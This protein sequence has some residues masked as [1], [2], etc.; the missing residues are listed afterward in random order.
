MSIL[1]RKQTRVAILASSLFLVFLVECWGIAIPSLWADEIATI[2]AA[3]RPLSALWVLLQKIDMVHG[4]YYLF[5]HFWGQAFGLSPFWLRLPS[6]VGITATC[7]V[8]WLIAK[9]IS[10]ERLAWM[11][12]AISALMP[13]MSWAATEGRSY[14]FSSLVG[15]LI[16]LF[17]IDAF[18]LNETRRP[19]R[20]VAYGVALGLGINLFVYMI[21]L[22][23]TQGLWLKLSQRTIPKQWW[24]GLGT[25][26]GVGMFVTVWAGIE[27][28]QISWLP[29]VS[30]RTLGEIL[31]GQNFLGSDTVAL[32]ATG[33]ILALA[34]GARQKPTTALEDK[35]IGLW[36]F[37]AVL[38]PAVVIG[39]SLAF[40]PIYDSRYFTFATPMVALLLALALDKLM[41]SFAG[42]VSLVVILAL[43]LIPYSDFRGEHGKPT[44]WAQVAS[45]VAAQAKPGDAILY[46]DYSERSPSVSRISIGYPYAFRGLVDVT[47]E[48]SKRSVSGLYP[49]RKQLSKVLEKL[50]GVKSVW[51]LSNR[52]KDSSQV[53]Q[54]TQTLAVAGFVQTGH[55]AIGAEDLYEFVR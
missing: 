34:L 11:S 45:A 21:L 5:M 50:A 54:V 26:I 52:Q 1:S 8:I 38:P 48:T 23:L 27:H 18:V 24:F 19:K 44:N 22:A 46:A 51:F 6:A 13:R 31:V 7:G 47:R 28:G 14:A 32:L 39:Y 53:T 55:T 36:A 15:S 41:P 10:G 30:V 43:C 49:E 29:K 17:F 4:T 40:S 20:W 12:L 9:R 42:W 3:S 35:A 37:S 2:S 25:G 33:L 16:C